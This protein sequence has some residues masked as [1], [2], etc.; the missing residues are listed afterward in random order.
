MP[1]V[2]RRDDL[3]RPSRRRCSSR[4]RRHRVIGDGGGDF[5]SS[6]VPVTF[7][8]PGRRAGR[9]RQGDRGNRRHGRNPPLGQNRAI[10][11]FARRHGLAQAAAQIAQVG[12]PP[13]ARFDSHRTRGGCRPRRI[14]KNMQE[15][16]SQAA[17]WARVWD[18]WR[19]FR[20]ESRRSRRRRNQA[21]R[22]ARKRTS[23]VTWPSDG[24][25]SCV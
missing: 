7:A 1:V 6:V 13:A 3:A 15:G 24:A 21:R 19:R 4:S 10:R 25:A 9:R 23:A 2:R 11:R 14:R 20:S 12:S 17:K 18:A 5:P 22:A 8:R 16:I